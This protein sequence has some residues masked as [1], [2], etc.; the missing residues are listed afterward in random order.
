M[1]SSC[2]RAKLSLK[3]SQEISKC[4]RYIMHYLSSVEILPLICK[5]RVVP[6]QADSRSAGNCL[7]TISGVE[8]TKVTL[9]TCLR[10]I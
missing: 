10:G 9:G 1:L 6:I 2:A 7:T 5:R 8:Q 4:Q 3:F